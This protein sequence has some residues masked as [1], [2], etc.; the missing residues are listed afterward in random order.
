MFSARPLQ[1]QEF[2]FRKQLVKQETKR[3]GGEDVLGK[4]TSQKETTKKAVDIYSRHRTWQDLVDDLEL[5]KVQRELTAD[6]KARREEASRQS[7][8]DEK[9]FDNNPDNKKT[10]T[11]I[12]DI[13]KAVKDIK[14][15]RD[16]LTGV[17]GVDDN[18]QKIREKRDQSLKKIREAQPGQ[19]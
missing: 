10:K 7:A 15:L 19:Q 18:W 1:P 3:A 5:V 4:T 17:D 13:E 2:R 6:Y 14:K 16:D 12:S 11:L 8:I 9:E